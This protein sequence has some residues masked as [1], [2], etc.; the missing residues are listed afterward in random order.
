MLIGV[1]ALQGAFA[2]HQRMLEGLGVS[3]VAVRRPEHLD[4]VTALV[5]PGGESTTM[6]KL[7][8][9]TGLFGPLADRLATGMPAFGTCAGAIML[10]TGIAAGRTDQRDFRALDIDVLRNGY[11]RQ[12]DSFET[13]VEVAG[14]D[15]PFHATFIRAPIIE[16]VGPGVRVLATV[17]ENAV[18]V[19]AGAVMATTFH[20]ELGADDRL[21]RLF[22]ESI[23]NH[24]AEPSGDAH[25]TRE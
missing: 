23:E 5:I 3:T 22:V 2:A 11:G 1:L 25:P 16:R 15:R 8:V 7:A 14:L 18:A 24:R 12:I 10:A 21:H 20:P 19:S 13:D 6:S 9:S 17:G 4:G